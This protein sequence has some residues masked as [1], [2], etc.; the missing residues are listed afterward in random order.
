MPQIQSSRSALQRNR[1]RAHR[2][3]FCLALFA[4]AAAT[5]AEP[6]VQPPVGSPPVKKLAF[7]PRLADPVVNEAA[8]LSVRP[9][10]GGVI[11]RRGGNVDELFRVVDTDI[12]W[13]FAVSRI[14]LTEPM[15]LVTPRVEPAAP[16]Q[17][18]AQPTPGFVD[19]F[20]SQM[21]TDN[22]GQFLRNELVPIATVDGAILTTRASGLKGKQLHQAAILRRSPTWFYIVRYVVGVGD[23]PVEADPNAVAA[24]DTFA[25]SLESLTLLDTDDIRAEQDERLFRSRTV[26]L[27][28]TESRLQQTLVPQTWL[29]LIRNGK[30]IGYS[31]VVEEPA[32]D[33][34]RPGQT[35]KV[36]ERPLGVRVGVRSRTQPDADLILDSESWSYV[37]FDRGQEAFSNQIVAK[38][39]DGK[40]DYAI[41]RGSAVRR[42]RDI[43][44]VVKVPGVGQD[45]IIVQRDQTHNL[46]V[47]SISKQTPLPPKTLPLQPYYLPA[48][49]GHLLPRLL[50]LND[51]RTYMFSTY[52][53]DNRQIMARYVDVLPAQNINLDGQIR[54]L[55]PVS[56]RVGWDGAPTLHYLTPDGVYVGSVNE[57]AGVTVLVSDEAAIRTLWKDADLS[58]PS[59]P[60][61]TK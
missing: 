16:G 60:E 50:P 5:H 21:P 54:L 26:M 9:P 57:A 40:S 22:P 10:V 7:D 4:T 44:K 18:R 32:V 15:E 29:R 35:E 3:G 48:A 25:A 11:Q 30:D 58:R 47:F 49:L 38:S 1:S 46:E 53:S 61:Q 41:E 13:E 33:L 23:G 51:P 59:A 34:P 12:G 24:V 19:T 28:W 39:A 8:G 36:V 27:N 6:A 45:Q 42:D 37:S 31:Y 2:V 17:P 20:A 55:V 52:V 14:Q 56:D 43:P